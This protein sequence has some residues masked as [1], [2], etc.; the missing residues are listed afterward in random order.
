MRLGKDDEGQIGTNIGPEVRNQ[1]IIHF[2]KEM[3]SVVGALRNMSPK[4]KNI[5]N[6]WKLRM[7]LKGEVKP[8]NLAEGKERCFSQEHNSVCPSVD[9]TQKDKM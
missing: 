5:Q 2:N 6:T 7:E 9:M 4:G 1:Q 3:I 8:K